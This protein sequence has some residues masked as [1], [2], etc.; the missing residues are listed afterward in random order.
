[1]TGLPDAPR[2]SDGRDHAGLLIGFRGAE[3]GSNAR[4]ST[5]VL[6]DVAAP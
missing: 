1:M 4:V 2:W 6:G 3:A 5:A